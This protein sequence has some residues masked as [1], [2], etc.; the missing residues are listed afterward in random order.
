MEENITYRLYIF[1]MTQLMTSGR[2]KTFICGR[3]VTF[4]L[5][6]AS[7]KWLVSTKIRSAKKS[8]TSKEC[9][10]TQNKAFFH[11]QGAYLDEEGGEGKGVYL[12]QSF[13]PLNKYTLFKSYLEC[14][15][16]EAKD[17]H[18]IFYS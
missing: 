7:G 4:S 16:A 12:K 15:L 3:E 13:S 14:Y 10:R 8:P 11:T 9:F 2:I 1:I 17:W 5:D 6:R 18:K